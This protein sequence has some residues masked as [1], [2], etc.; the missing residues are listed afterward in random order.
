MVAVVIVPDTASTGVRRDTDGNL[1]V[2]DDGS[3]Q[4]HRELEGFG[5]HSVEAV[6][7]FLSPDGQQPRLVAGSVGGHVRVYDPEA[8]SV[9]HRLESLSDMITD[10]ACI[11]SSS[12]A[13]HHPR[14]VSAGLDG[15]ARVWDGETGE[16]LGELRGRD[17]GVVAVV[18]WKEHTGGH[19][20]IATATGG[21]PKVWDGGALTLLHDLDCSP[22]Q[23]VLAFESAEGPTRLLVELASDMGPRGVQVWDPEEG[24]L[25][26]DGINL[27]CP[28]LDR[29]LFES[30]QGRHLLA[31]AG[32][33]P[34]HPRHPGD[35][36]RPFLEVWDLGE[37]AARAGFIK[38]AHHLG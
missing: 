20:R 13:P 11:A 31:I 17:G 24:R 25:L 4:L 1:K 5:T 28:F 26:H 2:W 22:C 32:N 3:G 33:R 16:M 10:V 30:A 18:V 29:H 36:N 37:A 23:R 7:S 14:L 12:A 34:R 35:T 38:P 19:D 27:D 6:A 15:T 9:L 21:K 8:G